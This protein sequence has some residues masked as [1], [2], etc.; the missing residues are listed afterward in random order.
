MSFWDTSALAKLHVAEPDSAA[1][2]GIAASVDSLVITGSLDHCHAAVGGLHCGVSITIEVDDEILR[3]L[4]LGPGERERHMRIE[5]AA[6]YYAKRWLTFGRAAGMAGL[7]RVAFACELAEHG[8]P[9]D[10]GYGSLSIPPMVKTELAALDHEAGRRGLE[11]AFGQGW[12]KEAPH[13]VGMDFSPYLERADPGECEAIA[14]A[15]VE[16]PSPRIP[17]FQRSQVPNRKRRALRPRQ[18]VLAHELRERNP[19]GLSKISTARSEA[20]GVANQGRRSC[21]ASPTVQRA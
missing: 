13:P 14:L 15:E 3:H 20:I 10:Y 16:G 17:E 6:R 12:I 1:F 5:L 21:R 2:H 8:I 7:D 18:R 4:P 9:R 19:A 11:E